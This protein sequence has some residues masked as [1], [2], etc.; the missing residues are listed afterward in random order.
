M[1]ALGGGTNRCLHHNPISKFVCK[2]TVTKT[3]APEKLV[4]STL[5]E[6]SKEGK[7]L[8]APSPEA[9]QSWIDTEKFSTQYDPKLSEHDRKIQLNRL[10]RAETENVTGGHF[11]AWKNLHS[12]VR[13]KLAKKLAAGGLVVGMSFSLVGCIAS[14]NNN[15]HAPVTPSH[16]VS[17]PAT[18]A[19]AEAPLG[20]G[21]IGSGKQVKAS[22]G[23]T[24]ESISIDPNAP[25]YKFNNGQGLSPAMKSAGY[26]ES[27]GQASQKF[28]ANYMVKEFVDSTALETKDAGF[29]QWVGTTGRDYFSPDVY[30]QLTSNPQSAGQVVLGD[31]GSMKTMPNLLHDGK[32][33][34]KSL[35]MA[36]TEVAPFSNDRGDKGIKY[37]V[38]YTA[39][40]RLSDK[41]AANFASKLSG[42]QMTAEQFL[43][44]AKAQPSV[45]DGKGE[46]TYTATGTAD[47]VVNKD[48][49]GDW[50]ITGMMSKT[51]FDVSAFV[52]NSQ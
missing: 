44:S 37:S 28:V 43:Q 9:V 38:Q 40:Y 27:D 42:G 25:I 7:S 5:V 11:H 15:D 14:G 46:T 19:P 26:T 16:S 22:D 41:E 34:E 23:S 30:N 2:V 47:I 52:N 33:R 20:E 50:K 18:T 17:A 39:T 29:Q 32:A 35:N 48:S 36:L 8:P 6:L 3:K 10:E 51:N 31:L 21:I 1:C 13:S 49:S 24:Y 4:T 45:K 12:A